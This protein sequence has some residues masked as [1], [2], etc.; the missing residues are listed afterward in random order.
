[1]KGLTVFISTSTFGSECKNFYSWDALGINEQE[2]DAMPL[3][4]QEKFA[5]EIASQDL[6]WGFYKGKENDKN[7]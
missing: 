7:A 1:M 6:E 5:W 4:E 2:F 3:E